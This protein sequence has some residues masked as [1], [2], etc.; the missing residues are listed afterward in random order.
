MGK[1][2]RDLMHRGLITCP[3][4]IRLGQVA[5]RLTQ[6]GV[7]ALVVAGPDGQPMGVIS[8]FDLLTGE[9]LSGTPE[10]L[11]AM[12][13]MTAGELMSSPPETIEA[14][15]PVAEASRRLRAGNLHRL[16]VTEAG[17]AVGVISI[18]DLVANLARTATRRE[19]VADVMSRA[20]V[21][22]RAD[23][24]LHAAAR[25][26]SERRS[27]SIVVVSAAGHPLGVVTGW[28]LLEVCEDDC[29]DRTV[30][31][32]MHPPITI[33]PTASLREAID[34]MITH[35]IHRLVVV[36]PQDASAM[37][38]GVLSTTD[39]FVEMAGPDSVWQAA[40]A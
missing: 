23:M 31:E 30:S 1:S 35:H 28:D 3:P 7:H 4:D 15:A 17:R 9:W 37:P 36:D 19:T 16:L 34:R 32:V 20:L 25:A 2:V 21:V 8:D 18:G 12:R 33:E 27:R 40:M 39:I 10:N 24:P 22:C 14:D 5:R 38:L 13:Q 29:G 6:A 11:E 26:M